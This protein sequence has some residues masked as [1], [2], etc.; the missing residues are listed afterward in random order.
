M[1]YYV[2]HGPISTPA[3]FQ[4]NTSNN[5]EIML[6]TDAASPPANVAPKIAR[7]GKVKQSK[8]KQ[9]RAEQS[10]VEQSRVEQSRAEQSRAE[11]SKC[12]VHTYT[13]FNTIEYDFVD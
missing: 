6:G 4:T 12:T 1:Q 10:R 9:S 8:A 11:Q 2:D 3:K 7:P 13:N 5:K